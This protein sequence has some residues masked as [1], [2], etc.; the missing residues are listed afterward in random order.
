MCHMILCVC[1]TESLNEVSAVSECHD[2]SHDTVCVCVTESLN[3]VST[4]SECHD[5]S[6]DTV[7][8]CDRV[9]E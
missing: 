7:C 4:V 6:H 5:V 8:V 2:V 9:A 3:E 1:V